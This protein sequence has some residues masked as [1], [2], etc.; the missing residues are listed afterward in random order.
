MKKYDFNLGKFL[1]NESYNPYFLSIRKDQ[2]GKIIFFPY[3]IIDGK[4]KE[5]NLTLS[6]FRGKHKIEASGVSQILDLFSIKT[7]ILKKAE[8]Y[9]K[10]IIGY[11][12]KDNKRDKF[13]NVVCNICGRESNLRSRDFDKC[14]GCMIQNMIKTFL[15]FEEQS[16]SKH[17]NKYIYD[18]SSYTSAL[19]KT[20]IF[21]TKCERYF[22]QIAKL[23]TSGCGCPFCRE[24]KGEIRVS[25]Y[26][27]SKNIS[28][29]PQHTFHDC[30][31]INLL[32]FDFYLDGRKMLIEY[33]GE[34]HYKAIF[35]STPEK[36][37]K[38]LEEQQIRDRIKDEWAK[39]NN[40][41]LLRIPYW[42]FDRIP[43][44][45]DAFLASLAIQ[46]TKSIE[47]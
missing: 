47:M 6:F 14:K 3:E 4:E 22:Y 11:S 24:S 25:N 7:D 19:E 32:E 45:I 43:E 28:F 41:P 23:H 12:G 39:R 31:H 1:K 18:P 42:D 27:K 5:V 20:K 35:G 37:Q 33:D 13:W 17:K 34:G 9:N 29:I 16:R 44:I 38:N 36:R 2:K 10:R 30:R 46:E 40:I 26:L 8:S 21:C 15:E